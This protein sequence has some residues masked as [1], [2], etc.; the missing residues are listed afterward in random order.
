M[1]KVCLT[2]SLFL[3]ATLFKVTAVA[4]DTADEFPESARV[5]LDKCECDAGAL[6]HLLANHFRASGSDDEWSPRA[7][8]RLR[9]WF[10]AGGNRGKIAATCVVDMCAVDFFVTFYEFS[11]RHEYRAYEWDQAE[12]AGF[13]PISLF[14]PRGDGSTRLYVFRD[15][16]DAAAL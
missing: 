5:L 14:F 4:G 7:E 6:H 10:A 12:H 16:F 8:V 2:I 9:D 3:V 1:R 13:L 11:Q 15:T